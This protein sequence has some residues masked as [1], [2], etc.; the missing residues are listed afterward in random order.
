MKA[1]QYV[2]LISILIIFSLGGALLFYFLNQQRSSDIQIRL[3]RHQQ[4]EIIEINLEEYIKGTV[5]A[6]MPASFEM[7]ALKAQAVCA[8]TYAVKKLLQEPS[9]PQGAELSDDINTC[10]AFVSQEDFS[11]RHPHFQDL[12]ERIGQAVEATRGEVILFDL[13]PIDA[14]YCSTCGGRTEDSREVWGGAIPYLKSVKCGYCE[15]S[16]HYLNEQMVSNETLAGLTSNLKGPL[17]I[18]IKS[19]TQGGRPKVI[20]INGKS[21]AATEVRSKLGLPSSWMEFEVKK[22][23][24][25]IRTHGYG[26]GV[27]LCQY[28][29]DGMARTGKDYHKILKHYYQGI[30]FY[31]LDY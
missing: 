18:T 1:K 17:T 19:R 27:G 22:E 10:Q 30:S 6:E 13:E 25:L 11:T 20:S 21:L 23:G 28:G 7:E 9:Y 24:T 14:L 31:K 26:H 5:A 3:Y 2:L 15:Q 12:W 8:R 4:K 16:S 29:A